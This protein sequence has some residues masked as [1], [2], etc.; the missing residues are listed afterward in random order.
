MSSPYVVVRSTIRTRMEDV[1][2]LPYGDVI[3]TKV[4]RLGSEKCRADYAGFTSPVRVST[5]Y[6]GQRLDDLVDMSAK[7]AS[8]RQQPRCRMCQL[9]VTQERGI[10]EEGLVAS[11]RTGQTKLGVQRGQEVQPSGRD[12]GQRRCD[13]RVRRAGLQGELDPTRAPFGW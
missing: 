11:P 9:R 2:T 10:G 1:N 3:S 8:L 12:T 6:T 4:H 13:Q 7:R 5:I